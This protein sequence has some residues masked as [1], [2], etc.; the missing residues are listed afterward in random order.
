MEPNALLIRGEVGPTRLQRIGVSID[1]DEVDVGM[2]LQDAE[3]VARAPERG[4]DEDASALQCRTKE[5]E[6]FGGEDWFVSHMTIVRELSSRESPSQRSHRSTNPS[7]PG[8]R[9]SDLSLELPRLAAVPCGPAPSSPPLL[10]LRPAEAARFCLRLCLSLQVAEAARFCLRLCLS[11][12]V[13]EAA[14]FLLVWLVSD[15]DCVE[16]DLSSPLVPASR[17]P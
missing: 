15:L 9:G 2:R 5:F 12:Q 11:L 10:D 13:A 1:P 3:G 8:A 4:V 17:V 6:D 7:A 14:R 16:I